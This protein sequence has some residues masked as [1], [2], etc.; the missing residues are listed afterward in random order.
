MRY[1]MTIP[2]AVILVLQAATLARGGEIFV[3]EMGEQI[4]L[5]EMARHLIRMAGYIPDVDIA[6]RVVGLRPGEKLREELVAM[7]EALVVS[8]VDKIRRV[9]SA[10]I[11]DL[12]FLQQNI[13]RLESLANNGQSRAVVE[14]L[15]RLVPT[16]RPLNSVLGSQPSRHQFRRGRLEK[17]RVADQSA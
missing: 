5:M 9:Q 8:E 6:I 17:L 7:D 13:H 4:K 11:P 1:F 10:W 15:Y 14:L 2:E 16:F 3:L 12:K